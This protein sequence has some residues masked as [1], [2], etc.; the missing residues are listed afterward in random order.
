M[1]SPD[2]S[3]IRTSLNEFALA[4][5]YDYF[6]STCAEDVKQA[7]QHLC[8]P[9]GEL[10]DEQLD[11]EAIAC[12]EWLHEHLSCDR[13]AAMK[14]RCPNRVSFIYM[15]ADRTRK[16]ET[17]KTKRSWFASSSLAKPAASYCRRTQVNVWSTSRSAA[18]HDPPASRNLSRTRHTP[19]TAIS[20][21]L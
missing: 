18:A 19:V 15:C 16:A 21:G 13:D 20:K 14:G 1:S 8:K 17:R 6:V 10:S 3:R 4:Y 12:L 9:V 2:Q 5:G 11:E 7:L